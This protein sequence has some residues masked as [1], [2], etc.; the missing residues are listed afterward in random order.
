MKAFLIIT[1]I[2]IADPTISLQKVI[3]HETREVCEIQE[4]RFNQEVTGQVYN[5]PP[6]IVTFGN[7]EWEAIIAECF[8]LPEQGQSM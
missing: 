4:G 7:A 6:V 1:F 5:D 8:D 3:F 2:L